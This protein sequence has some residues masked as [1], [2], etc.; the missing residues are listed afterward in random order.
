MNDYLELLTKHPLQTASIIETSY[1]Y[2]SVFLSFFEKIPVSDTSVRLDEIIEALGLIPLSERGS[3]LPLA[4]M[5]SIKTTLLDSVRVGQRL[6]VQNEKLADMMFFAEKVGKPK[7]ALINYLSGR[8]K[9]LD[10]SLYYTLE[11][12]AFNAI[13]GKLVNPKDGT[14]KYD[15]FSIFGVTQAPEV[16]FALG[17]ATTNVADLANKEKI[18]V[19]KACG[20]AKTA[21]TNVVAYCNTSFFQKLINHPAVK[22][23]YINTDEVKKLRALEGLVSVEDFADVGGIHF[24]HYIGS[25]DDKI[26]IATDKCIIFPTGVQNNYIWAMSPALEVYGENMAQAKVSGGKEKYNFITRANMDIFSPTNVDVISYPLLIPTR[27]ATL[28]RGRA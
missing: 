28:G 26:S 9:A 2:S 18:R 14:T 22:E 15:Y 17:T 11:Y 21:T 5:E 1:T 25:D 19:L 10:S 3:P 4:A 6:Q 20:N 24:Y 8:A 23:K 13:Q 12:L 7:S 27:P 16:N